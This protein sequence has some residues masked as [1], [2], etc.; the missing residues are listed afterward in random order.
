MVGFGWDATTPL[1]SPGS[2]AGR[3]LKLVQ[4]ASILAALGFARQ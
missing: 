3:G 2:D 1:D 4:H